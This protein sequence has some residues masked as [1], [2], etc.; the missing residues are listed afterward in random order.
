MIFVLLGIVS[1]FAGEREQ[2]PNAHT[3][4]QHTWKQKKRFSLTLC[5]PYATGSRLWQQEICSG[6]TRYTCVPF[7]TIQNVRVHDTRRTHKCW[8]NEWVIKGTR[9]R[10]KTN[11]LDNEKAKEEK[12]CSFNSVPEHVIFTWAK[13]KRAERSK[14]H[15]IPFTYRSTQWHNA[16]FVAT[17]SSPHISAHGARVLAF[18]LANG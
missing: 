10:R 15:L 14:L 12:N 7:I 6:I 17:L 18:T 4:T 11:K 1:H 16:S 13:D 2:M 9:K 3:H 5:A 8:V